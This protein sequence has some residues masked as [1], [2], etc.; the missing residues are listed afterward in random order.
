MPETFEP[1]TADAPQTPAAGEAAGPRP[2]VIKLTGDLVEDMMAVMSHHSRQARLEANVAEV[3][4]LARELRDG[5]FGPDGLATR[6]AL[7]EASEAEFRRQ[8][9]AQLSNM[10]AV[11]EGQK[12]VRNLLHDSDARTAEQLRG[13]GERLAEQQKELAAVRGEVEDR[14]R[15]ILEALLGAEKYG[16]KP[17]GRKGAEPSL[18]ALVAEALRK[19]A[20][21]QQSHARALEEVKAA[22]EGLDRAP[23][24][25]ADDSRRTPA[26]SDSLT[27]TLDELRDECESLS[28]RLSE[29]VRTAAESLR[30]M[31]VFL[32]RTV[33]DEDARHQ[34]WELYEGLTGLFANLGIV[35]FEPEAEQPFNADEHE[36]DGGPPPRINGTR[37]RGYKLLGKGQMLVKAKV[38]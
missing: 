29:V 21:Q 2:P 15:V 13:L 23:A 32:K 12:G 27:K 11:L 31:E 28:R 19:A 16:G 14:A 35:S 10:L 17:A 7:T 26:A 22:L 34:L 9:V 5:L 6:T 8:V 37:F 20:E 33:V 4:E 38:F 1:L 30:M 25:P 24:R 3:A 18:Y 36:A